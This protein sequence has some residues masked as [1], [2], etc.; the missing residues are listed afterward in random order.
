MLIL[1]GNGGAPEREHLFIDG[2]CLRS[3]VKRR[4]IFTLF[5]TSPKSR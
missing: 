2:G 4:D 3:A 1:G 5:F